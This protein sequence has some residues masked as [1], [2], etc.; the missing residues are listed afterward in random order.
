MFYKS[1]CI[2]LIILISFFYF[3]RCSD[4]KICQTLDKDVK[5]LAKDEFEQLKK[6][7]VILTYKLYKEI[8]FP[9]VIIEKNLI[10]NCK[11]RLLIA[12]YIN[13]TM[14]WGG[15]P[16][17]EQLEDPNLTYFIKVKDSFVN[18]NAKEITRV[19]YFFLSPKY[20]YMQVNGIIPYLLGDNRL[21]PYL[22]P[23]RS[24]LIGEGYDMRYP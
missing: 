14:T 9:L 18:E 16:Y 4:K 12:N 13:F 15:L 7:K 11:K 17:E 21:Q 2:Y 6:N 10:P 23:L 22:E 24:R 1:N 3:C 8:D 20:S 5:A 19:L